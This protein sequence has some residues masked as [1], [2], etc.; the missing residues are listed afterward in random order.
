M[1]VDISEHDPAWAGRFNSVAAQLCELFGDSADRIDH[2]GSTSVP[3][4]AAKPIID[5]QVSLPDFADAEGFRDGLADLSLEL[6]VNEDRRKWYAKRRT[7]GAE[8]DVHI[9]RTG[10]FSEQAALLFRDYLRAEPSAR[11]RYEQVKRELAQREW[12]RVDDYADAKGDIIWQLLRE[13]DR[14]SWHGWE[15]GDTDA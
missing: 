3:G 8:T 4:L 11:L 9:R 10:E 13:A 6:M 1:R 2:I 15:P 12:D 7:D 5:V 14:W